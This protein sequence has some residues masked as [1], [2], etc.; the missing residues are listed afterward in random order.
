[1]FPCLIFYSETNEWLKYWAKQ[2]TQLWSATISR[3]FHRKFHF[4]SSWP[5][6]YKALNPIWLTNRVSIRVARA[7][8]RFPQT[9]LS[10]PAETA[11][12]SETPCVCARRSDPP[13]LCRS[14][15]PRARPLIFQ[16][17]TSIILWNSLRDWF[18]MIA[19]LSWPAGARTWTQ[20][21]TLPP[22]QWV[23]EVFFPAPKPQNNLCGLWILFRS[24]ENTEIEYRCESNSSTRLLRIRIGM[25]CIDM[26]WSTIRVDLDIEAFR[27]VMPFKQRLI[28]YLL[29]KC[30]YYESYTSIE[31]ARCFQSTGCSQ[32]KTI[33][34]EL[35]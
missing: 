35:M 6:I 17:K 1:M 3:Q 33:A 26:Y 23:V 20:T 5:D 34:Q 30:S 29:L 13:T 11:A 19:R 15:A 21:W 28:Q 24:V 25:C 16:S 31:L 12:Y 14:A 32:G 22:D 4:T 18:K 7:K 9:S 8:A 10:R 27:V 2:W